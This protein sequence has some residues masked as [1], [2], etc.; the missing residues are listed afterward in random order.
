MRGRAPLFVGGSQLRR[1]EGI[2]PEVDLDLLGSSTEKKKE[3]SICAFT[4]V[5][6]ISKK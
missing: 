3:A 5:S 1:K 6:S 2:A 4:S